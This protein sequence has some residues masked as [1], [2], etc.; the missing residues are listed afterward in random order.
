[1][2]EGLSCITPKPP[3]YMGDDKD[4]KDGDG[5]PGLG[6]PGLSWRGDTSMGDAGVA[7]GDSWPENCMVGSPRGL[8]VKGILAG[9]RR[10][11]IVGTRGLSEYSI[12]GLSENAMV[13]TRGLSAKD[14]V[15]LGGWGLSI[16]MTSEALAL[17]SP[18]DP[19][20]VCRVILSWRRLRV[21]E[22]ELDL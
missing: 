9:A 19:M 22:V 11:G 3:P 7:K 1:M 20:L 6:S 12:R 8:P 5:M 10:P 13:G 16:I 18:L 21:L 4:D 17:M 15:T 2:L 14:R